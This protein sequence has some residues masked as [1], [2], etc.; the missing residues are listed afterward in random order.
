MNGPDWTE[1]SLQLESLSP[2]LG[3]MLR[4]LGTIT[5]LFG[6]EPPGM[7]RLGRTHVQDLA[8]YT[9]STSSWQPYL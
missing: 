4:V 5:H 2:S 7:Q 1:S 3:M 6:E 9:T 8:P